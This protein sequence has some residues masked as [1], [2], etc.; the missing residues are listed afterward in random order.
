MDMTTKA[1][2]VYDEI[3]EEYAKKIAAIPSINQFKLFQ[4]YV[5]KGSIV[6]DAGCAAGRDCQMLATEEY[7]VTGIDLSKNLL[8]VAK[9]ENPS[10]HFDLGDIRALP[11]TNASFDAIWANAV[12]HHLTKEDIA[13]TLK[14]FCRVLKPGGIIFVA[15][16]RG[17][18]IGK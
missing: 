4:K 18:A 6:L 14:E 7:D 10:L 13:K 16:K 12:I 1:V 17:E 15:T 3:S 9:R 5:P 11:F 2:L 8:A